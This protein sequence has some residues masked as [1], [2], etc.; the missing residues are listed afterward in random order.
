MNIISIHLQ[1]LY[2]MVYYI[3]FFIWGS[4]FYCLRGI[5]SCLKIVLF[6]ILLALR[7]NVFCVLRTLSIYDF[8]SFL[9]IYGTQKCLL[10]CLGS[11][12]L[13]RYVSWALGN[14]PVMPILIRMGCAYGVILRQKRFREISLTVESSLCKYYCENL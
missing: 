2:N 13:Y 1:L 9:V 8:L 14:V 4:V 5:E 3:Q 7:L 11:N 12:V 10:C 6:H